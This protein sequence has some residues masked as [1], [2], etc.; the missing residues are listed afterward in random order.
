MSQLTH[1]ERMG[2]VYQSVDAATRGDEEEAMRLA[3]LVPLVPWV[4]KGIKEVFGAE[5]LAGWDLSEAEAEYG[6]DWL[7]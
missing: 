4:A 1:E 5:Y 6:K 7:N 2:I 3:K